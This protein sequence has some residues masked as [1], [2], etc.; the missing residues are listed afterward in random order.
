M[1]HCEDFDSLFFDYD[2]SAAITTNTINTIYAALTNLAGLYTLLPVKCIWNS[3]TCSWQAESGDFD[4][5]REGLD[6]DV[7]S[8]K[9]AS[10]NKKEVAI[11]ISGVQASMLLIKQWADSGNSCNKCGLQVDEGSNLCIFCSE[12]K[13]LL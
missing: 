5:T 2:D 8:V 3:K 7:G 9:Y 12:N 13:R 1:D 6:M 4:I 10:L 11:W